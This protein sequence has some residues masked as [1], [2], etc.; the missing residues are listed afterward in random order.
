MAGARS[1]FAS[2][3]RNR[4]SGTL[5]AALF[6]V[7]VL[8]AGCRG[9]ASAPAFDE[10]RAFA[11]L[12]KQCSFGPRVPGTEAHRHCREWLVQA[13]T[14]AGGQVSVQAV[15]DS[16]YPVPGID[17]LYNIR[18]RFGPENVPYVLLGAHWDCRPVSDRDHDPAK[19]QDP[20]DGACDGA[21]GVAVLLEMA[22][23]L[24]KSAPPVGVE[25]ALFDG[26]D[27]G[28]DTDPETFCRG[29]Q[30]YVRLLA[31]PRPLH[32]I[33]VDM[34]G[35]KN[36]ALHPEAQSQESAPNLVDRLWA[37][38]KA[39]HA[40][41]FLPGVKYQ[42]YDDHIPFI[43]EGIPAVDLIDLDYPEWHTSRDVPANCAAGSLGQVGRVLLWHI[44]TLDVSP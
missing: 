44:Y 19:R 3:N 22:R 6:C 27:A 11:D 20:V 31:H 12:E 24:G 36:L 5:G 38:A 43:R 10:G 32:M 37:G 18:A 13:L 35:G 7:L 2:Q 14:E 26:E 42:V 25:I 21:S 16:A 1:A 23:E 29:S 8:G 30:A 4:R 33:L 34:V 9:G 15:R 39:V 17:S 41:A 40:P 28:N